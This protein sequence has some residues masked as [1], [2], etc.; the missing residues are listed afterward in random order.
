MLTSDLSQ[1]TASLEAQ[2]HRRFIKTHTP[3]DGLPF[4]SRVSY[5]CVGR[6]P[7]DVCLSWDNHMSNTDLANLFAAR[8]AAV[9]MDD[10][11]ELPPM[12]PPLPDQAERFWHWIET[13]EGTVGNSLEST[14]HHLQTFWDARDQPNVV[15]LHYSDLLVDLAGQ[16]RRLADALGIEVSDERIGE[17]V[18]SAAFDRMKDRADELAPDVSHSIWLDNKAFFN[19]GSGGQWRQLVDDA[20]QA[21]YERRVAQLAS[22]D[23]A[24]WVHD[25]WLG[26]AS[27][28]RTPSS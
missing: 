15:L 5:V 18:R 6:D 19:T 12:V 11:A 17:L 24:A 10:L 22:P 25:G 8:S 21:R 14:L 4:D 26:V 16:T 27:A 7:R 13:P 20:S 1:I 9:G 28:P 2:T 23:L 3:L